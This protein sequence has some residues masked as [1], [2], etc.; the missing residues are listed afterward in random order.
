MYKECLF[1]DIEGLSTKVLALVGQHCILPHPAH[2]KK[3]TS[4]LSATASGAT[5]LVP[6]LV[7]MIVRM[8]ITSRNCRIPVTLRSRKWR[9]GRFALAGLAS[10]LLRSLHVGLGLRSTRTSTSTLRLTQPCV[11]FSTSTLH[12]APNFCGMVPRT[13]YYC[14]P[15]VALLLMMRLKVCSA[16]RSPCLEAGP[17]TLKLSPQR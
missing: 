14:T 7:G 8:L 17:H 11:L 9:R 3:T 4:A 16:L 13:Y 10:Y 6:E 2:A 15:P 5:S 1:V 12:P